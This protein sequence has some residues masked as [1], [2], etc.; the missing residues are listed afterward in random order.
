[1][2]HTISKKCKNIPGYFYTIFTAVAAAQI[3]YA[4]VNNTFVY[5][6]ILLV[7]VHELGHYFFAKLYKHNPSMP[8][9]L[10]LPFIVI[11]LTKVKKVHARISK[12]VALAGPLVSFLSILLL[13]LYNIVFPFMSFYPLVFLAFAEVVFN[14]FGSDGKKYRYYSKL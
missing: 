9:I 8:I 5:L 14:Y 4:I 1:M 13:T 10:P 3:N 2:L 7:L 11:G 12:N 6:V